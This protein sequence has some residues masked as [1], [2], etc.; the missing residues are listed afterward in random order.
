M[1]AL[2]QNTYI[3]NLTQLLILMTN[4]LQV[5]VYVLMRINNCFK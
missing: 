2:K 4:M 1:K 5:V 3:I